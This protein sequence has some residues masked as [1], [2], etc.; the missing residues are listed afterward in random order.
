MNSEESKEESSD[1]GLYEHYRFN[2]DPGQV[3]MRIDK[4]LMDRIANTSRNKIQIA[5]KN[6]SILVDNKV[7]KQNYKIKPNR[8]QQEGQ[9]TA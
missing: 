8:T 7:V 9:A 3:P 1:E 4:F 6:G 2:V 5:A